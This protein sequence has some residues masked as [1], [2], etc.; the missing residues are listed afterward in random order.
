ME[1]QDEIRKELFDYLQRELSKERIDIRARGI[2]RSVQFSYNK[3]PIGLYQIHN[4]YKQ[5]IKFE[6]TYYFDDFTND[7]HRYDTE[8]ISLYLM[9]EE[10]V[11]IAEKRN[12]KYVKKVKEANPV[13]LEFGMFKPRNPREKYLTS[14]EEFAKKCLEAIR[15]KKK[16]YIEWL[17]YQA[18][19]YAN[20][21]LPSINAGVS[22]GANK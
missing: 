1:K 9:P 12:A 2:N 5:G 11:L 13:L 22:E 3:Q 15:S 14:Q 4:F 17:R 20:L 8:P 18:L 21:L 7:I 10:V 19:I 6:V 16:G